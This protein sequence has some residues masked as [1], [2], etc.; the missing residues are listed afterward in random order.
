MS[1]T[2]LRGP[3]L[4]R[5]FV[6]CTFVATATVVARRADVPARADIVR[7]TPA[8]RGS[9]SIGACFLTHDQQNVCSK[10][11]GMTETRPTSSWTTMATAGWTRGLL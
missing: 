3:R 9:D 4:G 7:T 5:V 10:Y 11:L 8:I 1:K 6:L 2:R